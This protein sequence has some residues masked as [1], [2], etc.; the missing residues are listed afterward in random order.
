MTTS[1][2]ESRAPAIEGTLPGPLYNGGSGSVR[3]HARHSLAGVTIVVRIVSVVSPVRLLLIQ[4]RYLQQRVID[5]VHPAAA[6]AAAATTRTE[7]QSISVLSVLTG[8][9]FFAFTVTSATS[10]A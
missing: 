7:T 5:L 3:K 10:T 9:T 2:T 6:A 1:H 4:A 8:V